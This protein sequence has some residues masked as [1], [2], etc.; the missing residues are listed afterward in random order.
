MIVLDDV[1]ERSINYDM[2]FSFLKR[3]IQARKDLKIVITSASA[4]N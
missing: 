2:L 4:D 1:H 3:I